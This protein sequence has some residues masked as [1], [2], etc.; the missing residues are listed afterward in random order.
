MTTKRNHLSLVL[1]GILTLS[2]MLL[3]GCGSSKLVD[4]SDENMG[5]LVESIQAEIAEDGWTYSGFE[6]TETDSENDIATAAIT[7]RI[8]G[9]YKE[10]LKANTKIMII[11]MGLQKMLRL[12]P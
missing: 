2:L 5:T 1:I 11:S 8:D 6:V 12:K 9:D 7:Y 4:Q 10:L 3:S